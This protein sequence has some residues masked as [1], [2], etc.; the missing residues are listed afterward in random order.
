MDVR[1]NSGQ[2]TQSSTTCQKRNKRATY[3]MSFYAV[4]PLFSALVF[5]Y[6]KRS[7]EL[8]ESQ[9]RLLAHLAVTTCDY[10][11]C[12]CASVNNNTI[13]TDEFVDF[14]LGDSFN[15]KCR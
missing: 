2:Q 14:S 10:G 1:L 7:P 5:D 4:K 12:A 8:V 6:D 15:V 3:F 9:R 11:Q 13:T